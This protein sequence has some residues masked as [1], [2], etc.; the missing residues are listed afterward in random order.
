MKVKSIVLKKFKRFTNLIIQDLPDSAKLVILIGPNGCGK[1]SLFDAFLTKRR[2]Y[3][4]NV[5]ISDQIGQYYNKLLETDYLPTPK[6]THDIINQRIQIHFHKNPTDWK[7]SIYVRS[8]YRNE[9][10]FQ[11]NVLQK[12]DSVLNEHRIERMTQNDMAVSKN[13]QRL[14]SNALE[15]I[16]EKE[17]ENSTIGEFRK[18]VLE[19]I[20]QS[21]QRLF[22]NPTLMLNTLGNPLRDG[23]FRFDKGYSKKFPYQN[24]SAGERA[25]FDLLLDIF[26]KSSEFNDTVFCIDEPEAHMSTKLQGKLLEEL[27]NLIPEN[28]QF[29]IATHSIGMMRKAYELWK[30]NKNSVVFLDFNQDFD[31]PKI[32]QPITPDRAFWKRTYDIALD[33]LAGLVAPDRIILCEGK[34]ADAEKGFDAECYNTIFGNNYPNTLFISVGNNKDVE[35]SKKNLIPVIEAITK[36][37]KIARLI[38][39]DDNTPQEIE[40]HKAEGIITLERRNIESYLLDDEVLK[41]FCKKEKQENKIEELIN[42][43]KSIVNNKNNLKPFAGQIYNK[44]KEIL[45]LTQAGSNHIAFMRDTLS[46]LITENMTVYKELESIIDQM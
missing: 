6:S 4:G 23:T 32:L 26:V 38:D 1:S 2:F 9:S 42:A 8:A 31:K 39:R 7:K 19:E 40:R 13:Y 34:S 28:S 16:F 46:P 36:G 20:K 18:K 37:V 43:K 3:Q 15:D 22:D 29:W 30:N 17:K 33:D 35:N 5:S 44:I 45:S 10:E 12:V 25:A 27:Y 41:A 11:L 14:C 21:M 24:L